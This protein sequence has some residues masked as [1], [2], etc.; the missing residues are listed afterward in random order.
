MMLYP[1]AGY[2]GL[3]FPGFQI[4]REVIPDTVYVTLTFARDV[5]AS[6]ALGGE[7]GMLTLH[8]QRDVPAEIAVERE[9]P[10]TL[11]DKRTFLTDVER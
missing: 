9:I 3:Y 6:L 11:T 7:P 1:G 10:V 5:A 8:F 4:A 2:P